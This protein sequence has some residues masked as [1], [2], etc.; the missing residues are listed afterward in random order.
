MSAALRLAHVMRYNTLYLYFLLA[1]FVSYT[2]LNN[3]P[4]TFW[5]RANPLSL[6][7][8]GFPYRIMNG[9]LNEEIFTL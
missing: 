6:M 8:L 3:L 2:N 4:S 5:S 1:S 7:L 9:D